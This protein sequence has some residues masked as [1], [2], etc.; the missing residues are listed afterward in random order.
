MIYLFYLQDSPL[1]LSDLIPALF[2]ALCSLYELLKNARKSKVG[3]DVSLCT[4]SNTYL[5]MLQD[6][7]RERKN[8]FSRAC[9]GSMYVSIAREMDITFCNQGCSDI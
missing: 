5:L 8:V 1:S 6:P 4:K 3:L 2:A 9:R 7:S